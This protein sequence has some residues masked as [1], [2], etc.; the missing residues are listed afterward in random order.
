MFA[1][2]P[3][4]YGKSC[5]VCACHLSLAGWKLSPGRLNQDPTI[6][7][8]IALLT[9]VIVCA[10]DCESRPHMQATIMGMRPTTA[11]RFIAQIQ[12]IMTFHWYGYCTL[13]V[14]DPFVIVKGAGLQTSLVTLGPANIMLYKKIVQLLGLIPTHAIHKIIY[15]K[16]SC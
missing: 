5:A 6:V 11:L 14:P 9:I 16:G 2:L 8:I 1:V 15:N 13:N 3:T 10:C 12:G 4:G 7:F